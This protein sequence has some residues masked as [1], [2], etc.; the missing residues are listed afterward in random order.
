MES[1]HFLVQRFE[2]EGQ[3]GAKG[4]QSGSQKG[5][6]ALNGLCPIC[7]SAVKM[8]V[9]TSSARCRSWQFGTISR[10]VRN[11]SVATGGRKAMNIKR[12]S[13][14][15]GQYVMEP[16]DDIDLLISLSKWLPAIWL[17]SAGKKG[18]SSHQLARDLGITQK[19]AWFMSHR[20]RLAM[21]TELFDAPLSGEVEFD[22]TIMGGHDK[23]KHAHLR[24]GVVG[25]AGRQGRRHGPLGAWWRCTGEDG[26]ELGAV[27][28]LQSGDT[29]RCGPR[30]DPLHR[31]LL[32][33]TA[34]ASEPTTSM[35][36]STTP[37]TTSAAASTP[38]A[39]RTFRACSSA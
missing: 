5:F 17:D 7:N 15:A 31:C 22:E 29:R 14:L 6:Q 18:R 19:S 27:P 12:S 21:E 23:N 16:V 25:Q 36:A 30:F 8:R 34:M 24:R 3:F 13:F 39:S 37:R 4:R 32:R 1:R 28:P 35:R 38:M 9:N 2:H 26:P 10:N 33:P 20:I 11:G